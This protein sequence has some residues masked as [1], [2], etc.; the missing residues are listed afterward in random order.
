MSFTVAVTRNVEDRVR[1]FLASCMI[2]IAPGVYTAHDMTPAVRER[3]IVVLEKWKVGARSDSAVLTW[4][5]PQAP[6]GQG[7][8]VLGA[9]ALALVEMEATVLGRRALSADELRS[10]TI[11]LDEPAF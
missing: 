4:A 5:D 7:L 3:V 11:Q 2:E 10:L 9:P 1:G 6:A 8:F